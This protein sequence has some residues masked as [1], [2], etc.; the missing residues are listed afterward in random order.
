MGGI[1]PPGGLKINTQCLLK[2]SDYRPL[3]L[4]MSVSA[5]IHAQWKK[6]KTQKKSHLIQQIF[7]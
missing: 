3:P 1:P 4:E 2:P 5:K 7:L 6:T